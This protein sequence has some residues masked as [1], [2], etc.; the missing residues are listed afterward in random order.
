M[1]IECPACNTR[2]NLPDSKEGAK[3]RC[4]ECGRVYM[5]VPAGARGRSR[6]SSSTGLY[7]GLG[8]GG[9]GLLIMISMAVN[10]GDGDPA[11]VEVVKD[12]VETPAVDYVGWN[13]AVVQV[14]VSIHEAAATL[15]T[16]KLMGMLAGDRIWTRVRNASVEEGAEPTGEEEFALVA[17]HEREDFLNAIAES[18]MTGPDADLVGNWRPYDG[19][20]IDE[21]NTFAIVRLAAAP[22]DPSSGAE[23][24]W[25]EW[26]LVREPRG[27]RAWAWKRWI[28]PDERKIVRKRDRGYEKVTLSDGSVVLEREPEPLGH[29]A[30]TSPELCDRID[31]LYKTMIDLD[32]T[33][34][35]TAAQRELEGIGKPAIPI[36]LTGIY[37]IP[38]DTLGQSIQ[39]NMIVQTLRRI[40]GQYF[41]YKPQELVGSGLGTTRERRESAIKQWFAWWFRNEKRFEVKEQEDLLENLIE[42]TEKERRWLERNKD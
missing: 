3:V 38:L 40:S 13:A 8:V 31:R 26:H 36:L 32:L 21:D 41:G 29:L 5:A 11:P 37:T 7:V 17:A 30:T 6:T 9:I 1:L 2:A 19:S 25:I 34:K 23:K 15:N 14:A 27:W 22:R 24:R 12:E 16:P 10:S 33:R 35:A 28:S 39:V 4:G 20:V 42:L 18:M